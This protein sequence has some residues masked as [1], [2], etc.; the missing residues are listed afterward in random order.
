MRIKLNEQK[1]LEFNIDTAGCSWQDLK[2]YLRFSFDG[3]EYGFEGDVLEEKIRIKVP[4]FQSI[5]NER[6]VESISKNKEIIIKG[7]LDIVA[8]G[9]KILTPWDGDIEIEIPIAIRVEKNKERVKDLLEASK[10]LVSVKKE[11][12]ITTINTAEKNPKPF[13]KIL[14]TTKNEEADKKAKENEKRSRF[15]KMLMGD[16]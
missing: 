12:K 16:K 6:L 11:P 15:G 3:I 8:E 14:K 4:P 10:D 9:N 5:I 1:I 2:A 7:R 13:D